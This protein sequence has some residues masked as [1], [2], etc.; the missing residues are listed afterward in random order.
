MSSVVRKLTKCPG[1]C[2]KLEIAREDLKLL[3]DAS[4]PDL[5]VEKTPSWGKF[6]PK[7]DGKRITV[8]DSQES[9]S[10]LLQPKLWLL[11]KL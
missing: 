11:V 3:A 10:A 7:T 8:I 9:S 1:Q 5:K 6:V 2:F 4:V